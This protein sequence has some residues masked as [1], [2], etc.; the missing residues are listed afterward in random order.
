MAS[1][2]IIVEALAIYAVSVRVG[3]LLC[4]LFYKS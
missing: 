1:I 3:K 2:F 4:R